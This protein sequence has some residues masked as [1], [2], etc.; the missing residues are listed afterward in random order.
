MRCRRSHV[1]VLQTGNTSLGV[2]L[3]AH[4]VRGS[5]RLGETGISKWSKPTTDESR[6]AVRHCAAWAKRRRKARDR[7]LRA[8]RARGG[9]GARRTGDIGFAS[10]RGGSVAGA[11]S[12]SWPTT[13]A[14]PSRTSPKTARSSRGAVT[15]GWADR[16]TCRALHHAAGAG[17]LNRAEIFEFFRRLGTIVAR[18]RAGV[19]HTFQLLV[20][21]VLSAQATDV[22]S[23]RRPGRCSARSATLAQMVA[24]G[25]E[26]LKS[27]SRPSGCSIPRRK[28]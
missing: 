2:S 6:C 18:N 17:A 19:R 14:S 24:L 23:T 3:L 28:T 20:A 15:R 11:P 25:E 5:A 9:I 26:G 4:L 13:N 16:Q 8:Q 22:G 7:M 10:L 12:T 1:A 27:R 21:V